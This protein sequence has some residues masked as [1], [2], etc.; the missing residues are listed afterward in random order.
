MSSA[1]GRICDAASRLFQFGIKKELWFIRGPIIRWKR[2]VRGLEYF[3]LI[4]MIAHL[5][6]THDNDTHELA[7][8][9]EDFATRAMELLELEHEA[10]VKGQSISFR[11][12]TTP[13]MKELREE[14]FSLK[15]SHGGIFREILMELDHLLLKHCKNY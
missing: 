11:K 3:A 7:R 5:G 4:S 10:I 14:L 9:M 12:S 15:K 6:D 1:E 2:G 13:R 8:E